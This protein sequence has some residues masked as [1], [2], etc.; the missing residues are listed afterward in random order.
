MHTPSPY[1][2]SSHDLEA[3]ISASAY[4]ATFEIEMNLQ[5]ELRAINADAHL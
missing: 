3:A 4:L 1:D 2:R 5:S